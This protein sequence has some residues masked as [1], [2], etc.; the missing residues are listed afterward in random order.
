VK[1]L[2][3]GAQESFAKDD[4]DGISGFLSL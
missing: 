2:V 4:L 3:T 1:N